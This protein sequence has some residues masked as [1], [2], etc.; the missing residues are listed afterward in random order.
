[1]E[2]FLAG[3]IRCILLESMRIRF[4]RLLGFAT[5]LAMGAPLC[6]Q[7]PPAAA[8]PQSAKSESAKPEETEVWEPVPSVVTP[9]ASNTAP[10]SD[11]IILFDG[12]NLDEWVSAQDKSPAKWIVADDI[13]TVSKATGVG[14]IET[15]QTFKDYQLHIE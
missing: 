3:A 13:L 5:L 2:N 8:K 14:N 7:Q 4:S 6:A 10:P 11:A 9:G 1:M 15:K 12:K